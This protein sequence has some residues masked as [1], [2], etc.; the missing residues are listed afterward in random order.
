M[1]G[2]RSRTPVHVF[3]SPQSIGE[4]L[5]EYLLRQIGDARAAGR[6]FLLGCPTGRTPRPV[7]DAMEARLA[8]TRQ[9]MNHV[10]LVMMDEYLESAGNG[11]G[12]ASSAA[13]WSCHRFVRAEI[14]DK[15][16]R[17]LP[18]KQQLSPD[19]VWFPEPGDPAGYDRR[20]DEAGGIDFFLLASGASDGHVAFNP[21]G[22]RRNSQTRIIELS[23]STRRDN[24]QTF[25][26]FGS[27][28][29]VPTHGIS[30][31]IDTIASA[32]EAAMVLWGEGKAISLGRIAD[33]AQ[34]DPA[35]PAT[36]IHE[37]SRGEILADMA[38]AR[39]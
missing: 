30:V 33:A 4:H 25:P 34:Y 11:F 36:V 20:I 27:L 17:T 29:A 16:N 24:L 21:P 18:A 32:K 3:D 5:A 10:V 9:D 13:T 12:Y 14:L 2:V 6:P 23:D 22:S 1:N 8:R 37:C 19:S 7:Y 28:A 31:G 26:A 35:W 38:A 15:W 39:R